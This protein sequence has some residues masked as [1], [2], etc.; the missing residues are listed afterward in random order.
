MELL[1]PICLLLVSLVG[2]MTA[3]AIEQQ[4]LPEKQRRFEDRVS[5]PI[6]EIFNQHY[7]GTGLDRLSVIR[8][9]NDVAT[10]LG[11]DSQK[12]RPSDRFDREFAPVPGYFLEDEL[13]DLEDYL[14]E[15]CKRRNLNLGR[16]RIE[17][18]NDLIVLMASHPA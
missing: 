4:R 17:T 3:R 13:A 8:T 11:L 16:G 12:L 1:V 14:F 18:L 6:E 15:Q 2:G 7:A 10:I 5:V 9:W